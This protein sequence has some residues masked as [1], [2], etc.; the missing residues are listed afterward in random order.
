ML[1]DGRDLLWGNL[2][3]ALVG[4]ATLSKYL[5]Q[6]SADEWCCVSSL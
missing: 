5:T 1:P 6:L 3:F 4:K 2:G